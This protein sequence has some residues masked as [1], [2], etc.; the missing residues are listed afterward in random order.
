[1]LWLIGCYSYLM[2]HIIWVI[3]V[4]LM[5]Q[6]WNRAFIS[7]SSLISR[8]LNGTIRFGASSSLSTESMDSI[9]SRDDSL[10]KFSSFWV[11]FWDD[12]GSIELWELSRFIFL[13]RKRSNL[14][15]QTGEIWRPQKGKTWRGHKSQI[16]RGKKDEMSYWVKWVEWTY[17]FFVFGFFPNWPIFGHHNCRTCWS[18]TRHSKWQNFVRLVLQPEKNFHYYFCIDRCRLFV[19]RMLLVEESERRVW[20]FHVL[21]LSF[22]E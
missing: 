19:L 10:G 7:F 20:N 4:I 14:K 9:E 16:R 18:H 21:K 5:S 6:K 15:G 17:H 1:M 13:P 12:I 8:L 2:T 11:E 22:L 3:W